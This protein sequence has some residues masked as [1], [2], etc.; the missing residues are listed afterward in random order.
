[1]PDDKSLL[2]E[3]A[4]KATGV[5]NEKYNVFNTCTIQG[6]GEGGLNGDHTL[7]IEVK[8]TTAQADTSGVMIYKVDADSDGIF[9]ENAR[10][11]IYV[12]NDQLKEYI[13]VNHPDKDGNKGG[14]DFVTD[15][16]GMIILDGST[17]AEAYFA[18]NTA[19]YLVEVE[20]PDGYYLSPERYYFQIVHPDIEK[21]PR[22][23]PGGFDG[24]NLSRGDIIYRSNVSGATEITVEKFWLDYGGKAMTVTGEII[25]GVTFELWQEQEG[26]SGSEKLYGTYTMVPDADG[27]WS[28]TIKS[29]PKSVQKDDGTRGAN[30]LYS[31]KEIAVNGYGLESA[32]N[33]EGISSG[34]IKLVNRKL[35]GYELPETGGT[36][37]NLYTMAGLLLMLIS[38]AYLMYCKHPRRREE[39]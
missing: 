16:N 3:Y 2:L 23:A 28:Y 25:S 17:I 19:Y 7:E 9:L 6:V 33:N 22:C 31:V 1:M 24:A 12:W 36:G 35:E 11:N 10:F 4:Y 18:Y 34:V 14:T 27:K 20:S 26:V 32:E 39:F 38:A 29:L 13:I 21:Y 5:E 37:T 15:R 30:Y 8:K